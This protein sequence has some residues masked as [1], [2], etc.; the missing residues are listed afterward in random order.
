MRIDFEQSGGF[1]G[2]I[3]NL[4]LDLK[5]LPPDQAEAIRSHLD[6]ANFFDLPEN[7]VTLARPDEIHYTITVEIDTM[8]HTVHASDT[9]APDELRPLIQE[10]S[11][12]ARTQRRS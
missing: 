3:F 1:M 12:R 9:S 5:D 7:L 10:L 11:Q 4:S 8:K 2:L 6:T